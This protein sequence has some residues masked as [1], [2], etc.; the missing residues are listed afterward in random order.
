MPIMKIIRSLTPGIHSAAGFLLPCLL[1]GCSVPIEEAP[2]G[3]GGKPSETTASETQAL[4]SCG[5]STAH[6]GYTVS[7]TSQHTIGPSESTHICWA[8][9]IQLPPGSSGARME[10][11]RANG[12]WRALGLGRMECAKK[13]SFFSNGGAADVAWTSEQFLA[14]AQAFYLE[15]DEGTATMWQSD[16][17]GLM[18]GVYY[19]TQ[20]SPDMAPY[21]FEYDK[22]EQGGNPCSSDND[23]VLSVRAEHSWPSGRTLNAVYGHN[24]FIGIPHSCHQVNYVEF[25]VRQGSGDWELIAMNQ[26]ICSFRMVAGIGP[27]AYSRV[28]KT[29]GV[30]R[31]QNTGGAQSS[32]IC[33]Y[34]DQRQ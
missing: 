26:G 24:F 14:A 34:F 17:M 11:S 20:P 15:Q 30:W 8:G 12:R 18:A 32:A 16:S 1:T 21:P 5:T 10:V 25:P 13:C 19:T 2:D 29:S 23:N 6:S 4:E 31:L 28:Y 22:V 7:S 9:T 33:F 3:S 27:D